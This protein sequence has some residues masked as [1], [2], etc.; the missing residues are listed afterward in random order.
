MADS[1][2]KIQEKACL[3]E[4]QGRGTRDSLQIQNSRFK[5]KPAITL[6]NYYEIIEEL[7]PQAEASE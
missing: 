7:V 1:K 6:I 3:L 2:F 4:G 5:R